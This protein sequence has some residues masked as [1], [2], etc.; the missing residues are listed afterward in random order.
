ML[1]GMVFAASLAPVPT[2]IAFWLLAVFLVPAARWLSRITVWSS[3]LFQ[4]RVLIIGVGEVGK[5]LAAKQWNSS[6]SVSGAAGAG[7][8]IDNKQAF[9]DVL[10]QAV[11]RGVA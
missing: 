2:L 5:T 9:D 8:A 11:H 10:P 7:R 1:V 4:E 6:Y 3:A